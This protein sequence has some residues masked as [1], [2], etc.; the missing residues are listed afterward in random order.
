MK[1]LVILIVVG[2]VMLGFAGDA[3]AQLQWRESNQDINVPSLIDPR[4]TDGVEIFN[5]DGSI[6]V[7]T[8]RRIQVKVYTILGQMVSQAW[9]PAG[10]SY[11]KINSRGIFI[12]KIGNI[13]Q[14]VAL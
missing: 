14:K 4:V 9:L 13:T 6:V 7:R 12:V 10:T 8:P 3:L 11:L 1:R 2:L 5:T